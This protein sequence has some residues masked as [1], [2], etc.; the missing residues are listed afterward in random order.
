VPAPPPP[1]RSP[2][3][4][5]ALGGV[6][7]LVVTVVLVIVALAA[8]SGAVF[9][10]V[11]LAAIFIPLERLA[12]LHPQKI[13]RPLWKTDVVHLLVNRILT[14]AAL[15]VALAV[16]AIILHQVLGTGMA[17][18]VRTQPFWMQ[19][20]E[21]LAI[22][23][24]TGYW[25][26][27]ASHQVPLLWRFHA[28]HHSISEMDWLAAGRLHPVDQAF[29]GACVIAPLYLLGF[30][31]QTFGAYLIVSTLWAIFI[32]ANVRFTFGP[33]AWLVSTPA[34]HHWHHTNDAGQINHNYAGQLPALDMLFGTFHRPDH[35]WPATYG[36]DPPVPGS[37][38]GQLAWS[39]RDV[40]H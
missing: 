12:S 16:P 34:Y 35:G 15:V 2:S 17:D 6:V 24:L 32:H 23:E 38:L 4:A 21:A 26:H 33:L 9:G 29:A 10:L 18:A 28:V 1:Y 3:D 31:R 13:L 11:V 39:F 7:A 20:I 5:T 22:T 19:F 14:T 40:L 25:A 27:R 36:I 30:S 8:R 37:Y